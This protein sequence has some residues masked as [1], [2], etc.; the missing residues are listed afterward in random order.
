MITTT[1]PRSP[2]FCSLFNFSWFKKIN[3]VFIKPGCCLFCQTPDKLMQTNTLISIDTRDQFLYLAFL[4]SGLMHDQRVNVHLIALPRVAPGSM[5]ETQRETKE[6][7]TMGVGTSHNHW[8]DHAL[9]TKNQPKFLKS[10][11]ARNSER[12]KENLCAG[13]TN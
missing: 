5:V 8:I 10:S 1:I 3:I 12:R 6:R 13:I 9:E 4:S 2:A 11:R 7:Q